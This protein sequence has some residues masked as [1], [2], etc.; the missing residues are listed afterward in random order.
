MVSLL[1]GFIMSDLNVF[2]FGSDGPK[3]NAHFIVP[4]NYD[5]IIKVDQTIY[6]LNWNLVMVNPG[7]HV[8]FLL[9]GLGLN[10]T[11]AN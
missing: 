2:H 10:H 7:Q 8:T 11:N 5:R 6:S 4:I 1:S 9:I 3:L